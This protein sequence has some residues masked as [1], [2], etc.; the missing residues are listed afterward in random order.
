MVP[1]PFPLAYAV[2]AFINVDNCERPLMPYT[3]LFLIS[4]VF[5]HWTFRSCGRIHL[6]V[7]SAS[8]C[9]DFRLESY[10]FVIFIQ[11]FPSKVCVSYFALGFGWI[12]HRFF[13]RHLL[14]TTIHVKIGN[15]IHSA[16]FLYCAD[17]G[18]SYI[19]VDAT[20]IRLCNR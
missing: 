15:F 1:D 7:A 8:G 4:V 10:P 3:N 19:S 6:F 2:Y 17:E 16:C 11:G 5:R 13:S 9:L 14:S 18:N 20:G 12:L